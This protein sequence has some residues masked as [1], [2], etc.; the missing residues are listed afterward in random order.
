MGQPRPGHVAGGLEWGPLQ[1]PGG[2][3]GGHWGITASLHMA[4]WRTYASLGP[5]PSLPSDYRLQATQRR[6]SSER[7]HPDHPGGT[8]EAPTV[9]PI[10]CKAQTGGRKPQALSSGNSR[11]SWE[12]RTPPPPPRD[13]QIERGPA[14]EPGKEAGVGT[15]QIRRTRGRTPPWGFC[16][17]RQV[18]EPASGHEKVLSAASKSFLGFVPPL[19]HLLNGGK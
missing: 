14:A 1:G 3:G 13:R 2:G 4:L 9:S 18:T 17:R 6:W 19:S 12:V 8:Y 7:A 5:P 10:L 11:V 15:E 16:F